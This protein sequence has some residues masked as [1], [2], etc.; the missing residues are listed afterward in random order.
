M[1][2][3]IA[4]ALAFAGTP[5]AAQF[6]LASN[7]LPPQSLWSDAVELADVDRDGDL[8]L[9]FA[10]GQG[11]GAGGELP[12]HLFLNDGTGHFT[13]AHERL[14]VAPFNAKMVIA[15]DFDGDGDLDLVYAPESGWP[16]PTATPR[17]LINSGIGNFADQ[18][19]IRLPAT[20][21]A[22]FCVCAGDVDDDGDLDLVF[23]DGA[24]FGGVATQARLYENFGNGFFFDSTHKLPTDL[25]NAQDV[26][27]F[28][29][30]RDFD[31]DVVLSGKGLLDVHSRLYLNDGSG[32]FSS[33]SVL[34][35]VGS[36][37]TY[38]V[39]WGDLDGDRD[40]DGMVVA[41]LASFEGLALQSGGAV[42]TSLLPFPNGEDDNEIAALDYDDDADLDILIG[43]LGPSG[44]RLYRNEGF[45]VFT[46]VNDAIETV[47]DSTLDIGLGDLDGDGD[48]DLVTA[49]GESGDFTNRVYLNNGP[50]DSVRPLLLALETPAIDPFETLFHATTQDA[51]Q[52]DGKASYVTA[53][54]S[55]W[56]GSSSAIRESGGAGFHQGGGLWRA[57]VP[58]LT[59]AGGVAFCWSFADAPGNT[60]T[61]TLR[62]GTVV[63]WNDLGNATAGLTGFP[64]LTGSGVPAPGAPLSVRLTNA[65]PN[66]V[67]G[68]VVSTRTFFVSVL[69]GVL[70]PRNSVVLSYV[71]DAQGSA[72]ID[73]I[74]PPGL[75]AC[76][77]LYFQALSLDFASPNNWSFSNALAGLER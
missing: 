29:W 9:L 1:R 37:A 8:D 30:D 35:D 48:Y 54:W 28:D 15:E 53:R 31:I 46:N 23:T 57:A 50:A 69:G 20:P 18:S 47:F 22:S 33:S 51:I 6:S 38:E 40:M 52:D 19:A 27:L 36:N 64:L 56:Q 66:T 42:T 39:E 74:W 45:G 65:R 77:P 63:D 61:A 16:N 60:R 76:R 43:S 13:A 55:A 4:I 68:L 10:N 62:L 14:N 58:T 2:T 72:T 21:M 25:Y 41:Q 44:E 7:A 17:I 3:S 5:L 32:V 59:G 75:P 70:V 12:Q 67:G 49:Q 24:T 73:F 26:T 34:D 11:Y 71:T